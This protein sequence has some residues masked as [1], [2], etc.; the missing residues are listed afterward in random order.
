MKKSQ[1]FVLMGLVIIFLF[2][3]ISSWPTTTGA[4]EGFVKDAQTREAI[5]KVKITLVSE[6]TEIIKKD[7]YT[8]KKGHFYLGGLAPGIYKI[9]TEKEG[10]LPLSDSVRVRL[11]E[12]AKVEIN[13]ETF[14][15]QSS[16]LSGEGTGLLDE[17][18]YEEAGSKFTEAIA[19]DQANPILYYYRGVAFEKGGNSD[20]AIE[21]YQKSIEMRPDF[22]LPFSRLG[23]VY[24]KKG[25]FEKAIEF[26]KKATDLGTKDATIF[27]N[28]AVCL[29]NLG[30]KEE[31]KVVLE[32][33]ISLDA[34]YSDAYYQLGIIY[35]GLGETARAK[36]LLQK[37]IEMDP[38]NKS[39]PLAKE[40]LKSL[41]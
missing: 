18:K 37:F 40:I 24:A 26:Y 10:Y 41:S 35:L 29:L 25:N 3:S 5:V 30:H 21:D 23:I 34:N 8:D 33:L 6:K 1:Y 13:L 36:E 14:V 7:I 22:I 20:K 4:V 12:T 9:T 28:Y 17:G 19:K 15:T 38:E 32:K 2:S 39:T 11:G 27:Y 16:K 31:A